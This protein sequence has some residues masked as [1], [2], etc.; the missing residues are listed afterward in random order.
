MLIYFILPI[1][2]IALYTD[3]K[4]RIV[5]N[6][7]ILAGLILGVFYQ[8][9]FGNILDG[10]LGLGLA[11][12]ITAPFFYIGE[13]MGAGDVKLF[14]VLGL[15]TSPLQF[16]LIFIFTAFVGGIFGFILLAMKGLSKAFTR[17]QYIFIHLKLYRSSPELDQTIVFPY[18]V[19]IFIGTGVWYFFGDWFLNTFYGDLFS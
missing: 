19:A 14:M 13:G 9:M 4:W 3:L 6:K 11:F 12:L 1:L 8:L 16:F 10:L 18:V 17:I 15:F 5:P 7:L 2:L